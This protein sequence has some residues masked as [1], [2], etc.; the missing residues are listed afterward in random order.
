LLL[1]LTVFAFFSFSQEHTEDAADLLEEAPHL[2]S[3]DFEGELD[4]RVWNLS[5]EIRPLVVGGGED[6][7]YDPVKTG[8]HT[9]F[10]RLGGVSL[11][12]PS[13]STLEAPRIRV[14]VDS[15]LSFRF[16]TDILSRHGQSFR[17]HVDNTSKGSWDG[18][19]SLWRTGTILI[20][21]GEHRLRFEVRTGNAVSWQSYNAVFLDDIRLVPDET[22][23]LDIEPR[24][25]QETFVGAP[26]KQKLRFSARMLRSDGTVRSGGAGFTY[27]VKGP[28]GETLEGMV[29]SK[30]LFTPREPGLYRVTAFLDGK[31]AETADIIVHPADYM[32]RPY[33]YP[34]TGITYAGYQGGGSG[35]IPAAPDLSI[36][37]PDA[38]EFEADGFFTLEGTVS[39]PAAKNYLA[40]RVIRT[41]DGSYRSASWYVK[42]KF[43]VRIW[44]PFGT[45]KYQ[46]DLQKLSS[47]RLSSPP[48]GEGIV[49]QYSFTFGDNVEL[50][51]T[52][53]RDEPGIDGD[54]RWIYPS[55]E[56]QSDDLRI[57]N[58]AGHL[59]WG[60][61][62]EREKLTAIHDY[63]TTTLKYDNLSYR[64]SSKHRKV[65]ALSVLE[66][67]TGVC[68]GYSN[69]AAALIRAA[70]FPARIVHATGSLQHSWNHVYT[71]GSWKFCD[72][73]WDDPVPDRGP[74]YREYTWFL[75]DDLTGGDRQHNGEGIVV[76]GE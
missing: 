52:N 12:G 46:V 72:F 27:S 14:P 60:L 44:L 5:G 3:E 66:N 29:D 10:I 24:G 43:S 4:P 70:G 41:D 31:S 73:T 19:N 40:I 67:R 47:I 61:E 68:E 2:E 8:N 76:G 21:A 37:W 35:T 1:L 32:R 20:P 25:R 51:V 50:F 57:T 65:D 63:I 6:A 15:A 36:R 23:A 39:N 16:K 26:D 49:R 33:T 69:A 7:A 28:E 42:G 62:G 45:G 13:V 54:G 22:A 71:E 75:L 64:D 9:R 58:L 34:G 11:R 18:L 38:L 55:Y 30:G 59:G 48:Q 17:V 74:N 56:V 53:T